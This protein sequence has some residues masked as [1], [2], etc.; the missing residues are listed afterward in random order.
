MP[1]RDLT[2]INDGFENA[3]KQGR[4]AIF[5]RSDFSTTILLQNPGHKDATK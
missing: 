5:A 3:L 4:L 1:M 2:F